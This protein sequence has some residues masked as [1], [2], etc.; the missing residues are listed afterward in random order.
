MLV[1]ASRPESVDVEAWHLILISFRFPFGRGEG[2]AARVSILVLVRDWLCSK[3][4]HISPQLEWVH[5]PVV[6][7]STPPPSAT[8]PATDQQCTT[9]TG[10]A[11][12]LPLHTLDLAQHDA[13][14]PEQA[15]IMWPLTPP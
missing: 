13:H 11:A 10:V 1:S 5:A 12:D 3:R 14:W 4:C 9:C 8:R 6:F 15:A 2:L 7:S